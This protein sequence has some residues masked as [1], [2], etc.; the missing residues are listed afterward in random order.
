MCVKKKPFVC[1]L[2]LG[3]WF[4]EYPDKQLQRQKGKTSVADE[5]KRAELEDIEIEKGCKYYHTRSRLTIL[6]S[7]YIY[8]YLCVCVRNLGDLDLRIETQ[9]EE[10]AKRLRLTL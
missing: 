1:P 10:E 4:P 7:I 3:S 6:F 2:L 9:Q 5:D 8:I